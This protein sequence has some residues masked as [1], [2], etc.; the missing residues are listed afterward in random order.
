[1]YYVSLS[2]I[3]ISC[4]SGYFRAIHMCVVKRGLTGTPSLYSRWLVAGKIICWWY[5]CMCVCVCVCVCVR[6]CVRVSVFLLSPF[7]TNSVFTCT[8]FPPCQLCHS[9]WHQE[10]QH[11]PGYGRRCQAQ[12]V[13][14][15]RVV[16][17]PPSVAL[18]SIALYCVR[19]GG[20][21]VQ[22]CNGAMVQGQF[23]VWGML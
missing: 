2:L 13:F 1:M 3:Q 12:Y 4:M 23:A 15:C 14:L 6:V 10:R 7:L 18:T 20:A 21:M 19:G 17:W 5:K 11:S 22:W 16:S 8:R 9:P